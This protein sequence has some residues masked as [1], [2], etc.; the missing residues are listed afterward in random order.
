MTFDSAKSLLETA[1]NYSEEENE[2]KL[3]EG[4]AEL[5]DALNQRLNRIERRVDE[6]YNEIRRRQ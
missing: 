6:I 2:R 1:R 5:A 3:A 4:L